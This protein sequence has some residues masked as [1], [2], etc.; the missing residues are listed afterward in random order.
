MS[1]LIG[2]IMTAIDFSLFW[3]MHTFFRLWTGLVPGCAANDDAP[4]LYLN[5][6]HWGALVTGGHSVN[7]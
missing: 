1:S 7:V 3:R 6:C 4:F 5:R 2:R